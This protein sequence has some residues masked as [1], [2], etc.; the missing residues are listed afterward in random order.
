MR[1]I[2]SRITRLGIVLILVLMRIAIPLGASG[3]CTLQISE[4]DASNYPNMRLV[5]RATDTSGY[6]VR[7]LE[8]DFRI[9]E[10]TELAT[11]ANVE[12]AV[13][14]DYRTGQAVAISLVLDLRNGAGLDELNNSRDFVRAIVQSFNDATPLDSENAAKIALYIPGESDDARVSWQQSNYI[15]LVN[16]INLALPVFERTS[17]GLDDMIRRL[18]ETETPDNLAHIIIVAGKIAGLESAVSAAMLSVQAHENAVLIYTAGAAG[19]EEDYLRQLANTFYV[20]ANT[21]TA[22]NVVADIQRR[23]NGTYELTYTSSLTPSRNERTVEIHVEGNTACSSIQ[24]SINLPN[25]IDPGNTNSQ[26]V[27]LLIALGLLAFLGVAL[28]IEAAR[29]I[30]AIRRRR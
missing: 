6:V 24:R 22:S 10:K 30:G 18:I 12:P 5:V 20:V 26:V 3:P 7:N 13:V 11:V 19:S 1:H 28:L 17:A 9:E 16:G 4:L 2:T 21:T 27:P 8:N 23:Y 29:R 14:A 25:V 15:D